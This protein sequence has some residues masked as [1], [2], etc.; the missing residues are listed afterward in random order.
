MF[1][2]DS[3]MLSVLFETGV[4]DEPGVVA[5]DR[6]IARTLAAVWD[7]ARD[8]GA[9]PHQVADRVVRERLARARA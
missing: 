5:R 8:E 6:A 4:V 9:L 3:G 2:R 1:I 7:R